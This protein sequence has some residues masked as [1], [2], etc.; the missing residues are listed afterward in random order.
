MVIISSQAD[1]GHG[2]NFVMFIIV[3]MDFRELGV[4]SMKLPSEP[5]Q[6]CR[7]H[8]GNRDS[9]LSLAP[10]ISD[11]EDFVFIKE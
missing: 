5:G 7:Q 9:D 8:P 11:E 4:E 3:W 10:N 2:H 6:N 1:W